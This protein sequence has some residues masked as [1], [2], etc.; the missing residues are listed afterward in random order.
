MANIV[1]YTDQENLSVNGY[2]V[3]EHKGTVMQD[4][5]AEKNEPHSVEKNIVRYG[6]I[7][8]DAA[9]NANMPTKVGGEA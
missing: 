6:T 1:K 9:P 8:Q 5:L 4:A 3:G 7:M 2:Y